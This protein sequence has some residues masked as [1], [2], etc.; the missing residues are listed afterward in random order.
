YFNQV[1]LLFLIGNLIAVPVT[2]FL[3]IGWL[4]QLILSFI[5]LSVAS[6]FTSLFSVLS[7]FC[8]NTLAFLSDKIIIKHIDIHIDMLQCVLLTMIVF[9]FFWNFKEKSIFK[10]FGLMFLIITS[11]VYS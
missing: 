1:P 9:I 4:I 2:T 7:N 11:Q 10:V 5:S 8:F 3:L 6:I